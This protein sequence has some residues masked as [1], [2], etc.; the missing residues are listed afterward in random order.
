MTGCRV[1]F[2]QGRV[3]N[4]RG[5][6]A[7]NRQIPVKAVYIPAKSS[8]FFKEKAADFSR[9]HRVV[10]GSSAA[11]NDPESGAVS[12][13][14]EKIFIVSE[15]AAEGRKITVALPE[16]KERCTVIPWS[17]KILRWKMDFVR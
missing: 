2:S 8:R 17:D 4:I 5:L 6:E 14:W 3:G 13:R 7:L 11:E 10:P 16:G 12:W 15:V 1:I 9:F